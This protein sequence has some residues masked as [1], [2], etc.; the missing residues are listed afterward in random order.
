RSLDAIVQRHESL[1]TVFD[2]QSGK[3]VQ[4]I[5]PPQPGALPLV[6]LDKAGDKEAEMLRR[7]EAEVRR[8]F[9]LVQGPLARIAL[10]RLADEDHVLLLNLHHLI[11]DEWSFSVLMRELAEHYQ[12]CVTGQPLRLLELPIQYADFALWQ[13]EMLAGELLNE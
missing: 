10:F 5:L 8:P 6:D 11:S 13:R 3:P 2:V 4:I 12:A 9:D 7:L 1:R